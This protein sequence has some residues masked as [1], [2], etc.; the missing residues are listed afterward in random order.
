MSWRIWAHLTHWFRQHLSEE[1]VPVILQLPESRKRSIGARLL[2]VISSTT[3]NAS[4]DSD[5]D[6]LNQCR[7]A[8]DWLGFGE[9]LSTKFRDSKDGEQAGLF[10]RVIAA[11][12]MP[13]QPLNVT[14]IDELI[15]HVE[16][17]VPEH[18]A[19]ALINAAYRLRKAG[20]EIP[21]GAAD[22]AFRLTDAIETTYQIGGQRSPTTLCVAAVAALASSY[23]QLLA[24]AHAFQKTSVMTAKT[25]SIELLRNAHQY[26]AFALPGE[27]GHIREVDIILGSGFRK[28]CENCERH[29][30]QDAVRRA[31]ELRD[32]IARLS[33]GRSDTRTYSTLWTT[34]VQPV[35]THVSDLLEE[36][37]RQSEEANR[38]A[39][40]IEKNSLKLD[41]ATCDRP[42]SVS[43]RLINSGPGRAIRIDLNLTSNGNTPAEVELVE[44][45]RPFDMPATSTQVLTFMVV[46]HECRDV[47]HI[48]M[49]WVCS[50]SSGKRLEFLDQLDFEQQRNQPDWDALLLKPP[51]T[52]SPVRE[53]ERLF[54]R[55]AILRRLFLHAMSATSTFLWGQKR[56]GKTSV[57]QVLAAELDRSCTAICI[58]LR[59]GELI[60]LH[61]GQIAHTI[62]TRLNEK[63]PS[64]IEVPDQ[65][66]FGAGLSRLIPLVERL[67]ARNDEKLIVIV[68]EFDD[69]DPAFYT[70]ERGRQFVKAL[71]SLSEV[72]LTFFFVGSERMDTIYTRHA[73]ELN[74]WVNLHLD[75]IETFAD[76]KEL[77]VEPVNGNLEYEEA[78]IAFIADYCGGNPFYMHLFCFEA[79]KRCVEEHRTFISYADTQ[80][81][82]QYLIKTGSIRVSQ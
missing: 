16:E 28:F 62:A 27:M 22:L 68:D 52:I 37:T 9:V 25:V 64:Q 6:S 39:L 54:G 77:I 36:G 33:A 50:D 71:R 15:S 23:D 53:K 76:C 14:S 38:P 59:M 26:R 29:E 74:K 19:A 3:D 24:S 42:T 17:L 75:H 12:A 31:S 49:A 40:A 30:A 32:Q 69:L 48:P 65:D 47:L 78:A 4:A 61:E 8:G 34:V 72:G 2:R 58:F 7:D 10:A 46:V 20:G 21:P 70:G 66:Y 80:L 79:F 82:R 81:V 55:D 57:L 44:P 60:A 67:S 1:E 18:A 51:Y 11:W 56:V 63:C 73:V 45:Q 35:I 13:V 43:C 41:L 5:V